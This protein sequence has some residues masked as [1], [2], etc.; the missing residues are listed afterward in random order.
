ME[1]MVSF[2]HSGQ[3]VYYETRFGIMLIGNIEKLIAN[4]KFLPSLHDDTHLLFGLEENLNEQGKSLDNIKFPMTSCFKSS[5]RCIGSAEDPTICILDHDGRISEH[6]LQKATD[7]ILERECSYYLHKDR[8]DLDGESTEHNKKLVR[9]LLNNTQRDE[10]GRLIMPLLWNGRVS[11]LLGKNT[12]LAKQILKSNLKKLS[13]NDEFLRLMDDN[14]KIQVAQNLIERIDNLDKFCEEHPEYSVLPHMGIFKLDRSTTKCR[15]VFLSNLCEKQSNGS[16]SISH[17]QAMWAGPC[18]NQKLSTALL[19]LRFDSHLLCFDLKKA[20]QQIAL[21]ETDQS[22]LLFFWFKNV[23]KGD[24]TIIAYKNLRLSFGLRCSPTILMIGL[25]KILM[26]DTEGDLDN[27]KELK[28]L[29]YSLIYMD[30][31]AFT[32]N[33]SESLHWGFDKLNNIFNP[34]KFE[35]QQFVTNDVMLQEK[36]DKNLDEVTPDVVKI[37]GLKWNRITDCISSPKLELDSKANTK[38]L[39]LKSIASNFDPYNY[40]G[41]IL[42]RARLF[43]HELQLNTS[44]GWDTELSIEQQ[45]EWRNIAKQVN[46]TPPIEVP[47]VVGE[48]NGSYRLIAFTDSSKIIYGTTI[49][50]QCI[51]TKQVSF[52]LAKNRLVNKQLESKSIPSLEFQG[53]VLGTETLLD[54]SKDLAGP[55]CPKP[56]RIVESVL[57]TDSIV[58]LSW[59]NSYV[60]KLDKM[61]KRSVFIMNRLDHIQ[62]TCENNPVRFC[63]VSGILNP[64]DCITRPMSYKQLLK[65]NYFTGPEFL[66]CERDELCSNADT[67][68][69]VVPNPNFNPLNEN[70]F[71]ISASKLSESQVLAE[72][73]PEHLVVLD[74]C[75]SFSKLVRIHEYVLKFIA[76]LKRRANSVSFNFGDASSFHL[77]ATRHIIRNDQRIW[78]GEVFQYLENRNKRVKDIP[79]IIAQLNVY[80]DDHGLLRIRSKM[81]KWRKD[82]FVNFPILLHKHSKLTRLVIKDFHDKF[83]HAG[84]YSLLSEMR[85]KFWIPHYFSVVKKVIKECV[86]CKRFKERTVKVNQSAYRDFRIDPPS[87]PFRYIFIDHFGP[88]N[89][90]LNGKKSK[91]WVLCLTCLWSRAINLKICLDLTTKEFLRAFQMHSYQYGIP[92]LVLSDLG[93]QLVAGAN[94]VTNFLGDPESQAYFEENGVKS[95]KFQQYPKGC[96]KLGGLVETCVKMSK[97]LIYGALRNN[98]LDFRDFEFFVEQTVHLVNR[99]PIAFKEGL[100]DSITDE[101]P[102]AITPEILIHGHEL[103]SINIIPDLQGNPDED[104]NWTAD[105]HVSKVLDK[106]QKLRNVRSRLINIYNSE[107]IAHLV[108]QATDEK[109]RYKPVT[110]KR[111]Q[112]GDIVLLKEPHMKPSN[113]PMGIVKKVK[114]ND[115]DEVTDIEV[116]KGASRET[117][118]RHVTSVIP[119]LS[120]VTND[121]EEKVDIKEDSST[122]QRKKREAAVISEA[123]TRDMLRN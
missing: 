72:S 3:C 23:S 115:L 51:E 59:I 123:R 68:D 75:S 33:D 4:L 37:F 53:I 104:L 24:F 91:V 17:N 117:V 107:F 85:K 41:P 73:N 95:I 103:L 22:K 67:F 111:I 60:N 88:Y 29:I 47:R 10:E 120:P 110:H 32:A 109:S 15:M 102:D 108:S 122:H 79:N 61:N 14:I 38:R 44:L 13:K 5:V 69:I 119:L 55:Q 116:F 27:L 101:V 34:Y 87:I 74:K 2:G 30:N 39:I 64:A 99:R 36:I 20:F 98:V 71:S 84:V 97:R 48:R 8:T 56:I 40:N 94:V 114:L 96:N 9:Y 52:V 113:Y 45:R 106:Y 65:T 100:R 90:K 31:G 118:R 12:N 21:N 89:V 11:H 28:K 16:P 82:T 42:N 121:S 46:M 35:L 6:K 18:I 80:M 81:P 1:K 49:F 25:Y 70:S 78:Y 57:Y 26:L 76:L 93:S 86:I 92:Q 77:E 83:S 63:F 62:R 66:R 50:I 54:L 7:H 105:D 43:M 58:S 19:L 112:I